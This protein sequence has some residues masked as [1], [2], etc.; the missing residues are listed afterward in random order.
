M[1]G[2]KYA[3]KQHWTTKLTKFIVWSVIIVCKYAITCVP[4]TLCMSFICMSHPIPM[5]GKWA[6]KE[7]IGRKNNKTWFLRYLCLIGSMLCWTNSSCI[8]ST[9]HPSATCADPHDMTNKTK[10]KW[11]LGTYFHMEHVRAVQSA[12]LREII[13]R[14]LFSLLP[15]MNS[16]RAAVFPAP[17]PYAFISLPYIEHSFCHYCLN[18]F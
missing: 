15:T 5:N 13:I 16:L 9:K 6:E 10:I 4:N 2:R 3:W 17:E 7:K 18:H 14:T 8:Q 12:P 11:L 1:Y